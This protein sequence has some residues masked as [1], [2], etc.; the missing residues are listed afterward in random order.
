MAS[1]ITKESAKAG[2]KGIAKFLASEGADIASA[3]LDISENPNNPEKVASS[4]VGAAGNI[5]MSVGMNTAAFTAMA[6]AAATG[7]GI[8]LVI[9]QI[10]F[11]FIDAFVNPY[12]T[13]FNKDLKEL[14]NT[15]DGQINTAMLANGYGFPLEVKPDIMPQ[16]PEEI[17]VFRG[18][19]RKY[20]DDRGLITKEDVLEE[21]NLITELRKFKRLQRIT[22]NPYFQT[23]G[24]LDSTQQ[25][26]ALLIAAKAAYK[27][28]Y[29][30]PKRP[31]LLMDYSKYKPKA[32][33]SPPTYDIFKNDWQLIVV[34]IVSL[35]SS[36]FISLLSSYYLI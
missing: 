15:I 35:I 5:G 23:Q 3:G 24:L 2:A 26:I 10:T 30:A 25:N 14:K 32:K 4:V 20:Y 11:A 27:K 28:G 21:E 34:I 16:T 7:I 9:F 36:C 31:K 19:I 12:Q 6:G 8:A 33:K 29:R 22:S 17:E 1:L 13:Y 18:L